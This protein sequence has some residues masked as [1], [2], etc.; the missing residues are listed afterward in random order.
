[1]SVDQQGNLFISEALAST[2]REV[3]AATGLLSTVAGNGGANFNGDGIPAT[4]AALGFVFG[5][6]VWTVPE[7]YTSRMVPGA[8][9]EWTPTV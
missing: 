6:V 7:T 5:S 2:V 4:S 3:S 1:V 9:V 8:F